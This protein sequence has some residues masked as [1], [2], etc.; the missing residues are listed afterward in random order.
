MFKHKKWVLFSII[1]SV[2]LSLAVAGVWLLGSVPVANAASAATDKAGTLIWASTG[3]GV[4]GVDYFA[5]GGP[6]R[7]GPW[8]GIDYQQLLAD[9]LGITVQELQAA[10]EAAQQAAIDQALEQGLITEEQAADMEARRALQ[11]YLDR[12]AFLAQALGMT[13]EE[14][15]AAFDEGKTPRDLMQERDL[16]PQTVRESIEAAVEAALAQAV[17]DGVI[18][19]EQADEIG[20]RG[21]CG[22]PMQGPGLGGRGSPGGPGRGRGGFGGG[23]PGRPN[24]GG[25]D[26]VQ[27]QRPGRGLGA[28]ESL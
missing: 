24:M 4:D 11:S 17:A 26:G 25:D 9:E 7:G 8:P 12:D 1:G 22:G 28:D 21:G 19:Q 18:T 20:T 13:V 15:R 10:Q 5:Q 16:D 2:I 14:L 6:G 27:F 23:R 3:S